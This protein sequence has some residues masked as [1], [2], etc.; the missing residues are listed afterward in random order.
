MADWEAK[1]AYH[2]DINN[3]KKFNNGDGISAEDINA[4]VQAVLYAQDIQEIDDAKLQ[5]VKKT[6]P[7]VPNRPIF[8]NKT[9]EAIREDILF[10]ANSNNY[11]VSEGVSYLL[12]YTD[13]NRKAVKGDKFSAACSSLDGYVFNISAEIVSAIENGTIYFKIIDLDTDESDLI[14]LHNPKEIPL[15]VDEVLTLPTPHENIIVGYTNSIDLA[16]LNKTPEKGERFWGICKSSDN[17]VYG[18]AAECTG[19]ISTADGVDYAEFKFTEVWLLHN[20]DIDKKV[21]EYETR[22]STL[23]AKVNALLNGQ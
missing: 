13:F 12:W 6:I 4:V 10:G 14:L 2:T 7:L 18:F 8:V 21:A 9:Y 16:S 3:G 1:W 19:E 5:A 15:V 11:W 17:Y 23:E 22:I 20:A